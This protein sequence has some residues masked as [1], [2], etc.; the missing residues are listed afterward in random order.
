MTRIS[1]QAANSVLLNRIFR[2]QQ[3]V[4]ERQIQV[5]SERKSQNY[6]GIAQDSRRLINIENTRSTLELDLS[7]SIPGLRA[8]LSLEEIRLGVEP[9][10]AQRGLCADPP[11]VAALDSG[12]EAGVTIQSLRLTA[13]GL[14]LKA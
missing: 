12:S 8:G 14:R 4:Y 5:T 11:A 10:L 2:T 9:W 3:N 13:Y 1:T 6:H 7:A